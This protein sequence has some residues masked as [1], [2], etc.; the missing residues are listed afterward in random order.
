M[1]ESNLDLSA[2]LDR[3][4]LRRVRARYSQAQIVA[5]MMHPEFFRAHPM[6]ARTHSRRQEIEDRGHQRAI[7]GITD[8]QGIASENDIGPMRGARLVA[9]AWLDDE[10]KQRL[11]TDANT[12]IAEVGFEGTQAELLIVKENTET[13]HNVV[14]CTLCSCYPWAVLGLPPTWYKEPAYRSRVVR[15]PRRVLEEFGL[16]LAAER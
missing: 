2:V 11:L 5:T 15:E 12:V 7:A 6:P 8:G 1:T 9:R 13:V 16:S 14:V 10:F 4:Q 3:P